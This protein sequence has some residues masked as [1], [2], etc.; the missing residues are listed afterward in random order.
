LN[1]VPAGMVS[2]SASYNNRHHKTITTDLASGKTIKITITLPAEESTT[3]SPS[4][5]TG[6]GND[7]TAV[8]NTGI[9]YGTVFKTKEEAGK[10]NPYDLEGVPLPNTAVTITYIYNSKTITKTVNSASNGKFEFTGL[11]LNI[12]IRISSRGTTQNKTLTTES[13][14]QYVQFGWDGEITIK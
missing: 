8:N 14:K 10:N 9:L 1:N 5:T 7:N 11:P 4:P 3:A 6:Q 12:S 13:I 2:V